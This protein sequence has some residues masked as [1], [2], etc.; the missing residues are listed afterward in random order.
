MQK[1]ST[2]KPLANTKVFERETNY[3]KEPFYAWEC[4]SLI[5]TYRSIDFVIEDELCLMTFINYFQNIACINKS[6]KIRHEIKELEK[7]KE[8]DV[9]TELKTLL[10]KRELQTIKPQPMSKL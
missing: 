3:I 4:V 10:L 9:S 8:Q 2:L 6:N 5:T 7:K 1:K